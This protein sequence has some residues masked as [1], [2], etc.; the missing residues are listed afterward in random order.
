MDLS[1]TLPDELWVLDD[2]NEI[3]RYAV[4]VADYNVYEKGGKHCLCIYARAP[5]KISPDD[6]NPEPWIELNF[7]STK[8][9]E[10]ELNPNIVRHTGA[11]DDVAGRWLTN[12]YY[13][14]H[15]GIE[16]V[17]VRV[18]EVLPEGRVLLD[19]TGEGEVGG[20]IRLRG[21]FSSNPDRKRSFD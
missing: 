21:T 20:E 1:Q 2:E 13:Y 14:S 10:V 12:I 16:N 11:Y 15:A 19:I 18:I 6:S 3:H 17:V 7:D 5:R 9:N 8:R 4:S